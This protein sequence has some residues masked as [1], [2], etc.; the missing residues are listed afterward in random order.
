MSGQNGCEF[1]QFNSLKRFPI[2]D[3]AKN[4]RSHNSFSLQTV[5]F[6]EQFDSRKIFNFSKLISNWTLIYKNSDIL[7]VLFF[8][9]N[10]PSKRL[11]E[12]VIL[13]IILPQLI[14]HKFRMLYVSLQ[15]DII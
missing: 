9:R 10:S 2:S 14:K 3:R 8:W 15:Y 4:K 5:M 11:F 12:I 6:F 13:K 1:V 7:V